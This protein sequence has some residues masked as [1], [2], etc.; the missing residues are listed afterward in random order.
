MTPNCSSVI[1]DNITRTLNESGAY[2]L[3][4][5]ALPPSYSISPW[6]LSPTATQQ[7]LLLSL[8][9]DGTSR[10][11]YKLFHKKESN[12]EREKDR[13]NGGM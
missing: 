8:L 2:H 7:S 1:F 11:Y 10:L 4:P 6:A 9:K 3:S 12:K 5:V 13:N